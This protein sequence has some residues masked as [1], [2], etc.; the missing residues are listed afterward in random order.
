MPASVAVTAPANSTMISRA[1]AMTATWTAGTGDV[2]VNLSQ[3]QNSGTF[4]ASHARTIRCTFPS[5]DGMGTVPAELVSQ[6]ETGMS[7]QLYVAGLAVTTVIAGAYEIDVR[8][9][10]LDSVRQLSVGP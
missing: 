10:A 4:P 1:A 6:L 7:V 9:I 2:Y 8:A 5:Q 3:T